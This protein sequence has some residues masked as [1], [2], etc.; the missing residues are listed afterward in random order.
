MVVDARLYLN[1]NHSWVG[2]L[3]VTLENRSTG[4]KITALD[5]PGNPAGNCAEDNI[6]TILDGAAAQPADDQCATSP[7]A[8]SGIYLPNQDLHVFSGAG[9]SGTWRLNVSDQYP[10]DVGSL[11]HWCVEA[12]LNSSLPPATPTP[13]AVS[14]PSSAEVSGM[15]GQDQSLNLDCESRSAVD[16]AKHYGFNIGEFDFLYNLPFTDDPETGFV[17]NPNGIWGN[18]PPADYGVHALPVSLNLQSYGVTASSYR[19]LSWRDLQAE[20]ASGNPAIVWI[21]G[22]ASRTLVNGIPR[23]YTSATTV[24]TTVVARYEHTVIVTGYSPGYVTVLNGSKFV[25]IRIDQFLD[26]WSVLQFM[27]VLGRP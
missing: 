16:W 3:V 7:M 1:I 27:A 15:T 23:Y 19:S 20:I 9:I 18:I 24:D 5:R 12:S 8:I 26:S 6:I 21:I 2:D 4:K 25:D 10:N 13:T 14:L 11:N 22:G 17:G